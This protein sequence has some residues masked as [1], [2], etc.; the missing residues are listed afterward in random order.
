MATRWTRSSW[1]IASSSFFSAALLLAGCDSYVEPPDVTLVAPET[2]TFF[3]GDPIELSFDRPVTTA[4]LEVWVWPDD[5]DI[6]NDLV[7]GAEPL[8]TKCTAAGSPCGT[9]T[10]EMHDDRKGATL[11]FDPEVLGRPDVPLLIEV[12]PGLESDEGAATGRSFWFDFQF[13]PAERCQGE[14]EFDEGNYL[15]VASTTEPVP[16][17]LNLMGDVALGKNGAFAAIMAE[18]DPPAGSDAPNNTSDAT[19]LEIDVGGNAFALVTFGCLREAEAGERFFETEPVDVILTLGPATVTIQTTR[20]TGKVTKGANGR[21]RVDGT[22]SFSG[23]VLQIA[24]NDPFQYAAGSTTFEGLFVEP[25]DVPSGTPDVCG[26]Q[27]GVVPKQC[28][29]PEDFPGEGYCEAE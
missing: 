23:A 5:R 9:A 8:L 12:R 6:E 15:F 21:D 10:F 20:L 19:E 26:D 14:V 17:I 22:L 25:E 4:T 13:K 28:I 11:Q 1:R 2:G 27:C 24:E 7:F 18:A 29:V 3:S 16:A